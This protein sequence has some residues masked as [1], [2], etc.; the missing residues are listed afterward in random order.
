[1]SS[2]NPFESTHSR[3][4]AR[5]PG[6]R[7]AGLPGTTRPQRRSNQPP[8]PLNSD[9]QWLVDLTALSRCR[10]LFTRNAAMPASMP[11]DLR[12]HESVMDVPV[13]YDA[14]CRSHHASVKRLHPEVSWDDAYPAYAIAL[15]AH[16]VLC[17]ALDAE[18]EDLLQEHWQSLRGHS[19][20]GWSQARMLVADGCSALDRLDP[21]AMHR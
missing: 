3:T 21:L 20:L 4:S 16:A 6:D 7:S 1:M 11:G 12:R 8:A 17:V 15:A 14:F 10:A 5:D 13:A 19:S 9:R 18:Q 2:A